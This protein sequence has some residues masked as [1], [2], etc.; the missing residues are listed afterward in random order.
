MRPIVCGLAALLYSWTAAWP[1][2]L[3]ND[4]RAAIAHNDFV[5][6]E[7]LTR[8][9]LAKGTTPEGILALSWLGRG[10]LAANQL[11]KADAYAGETRDLSMKLLRTRKLDD[12][13]SLPTAFGAYM[14]VHAQVLAARGQVADAVEFLQQQL[15]IYGGTSLHE[16]IQKNINLLSLEGKPAPALEEAEWLGAKPPAL[17]TLRGHP[18]LLFFWAHWCP[19]CKAEAPVIAGLQKS[20]GPKGL[21]VISPTKLYGY[22]NRG[23]EAQADVEKPYIEQV[24]AHYYSTMGDMFVPVSSR[25]FQVYGVST[26]PTLVLVDRN[27]IVRTYHPGNMTNDELSAQVQTLLSK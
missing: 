1:A 11:D 9:S 24:R 23:D 7:R 2:G 13:Q 27:G 4:V 15:E 22:V 6:A 18:V 12:E 20:F 3:V 5:A 8:E 26:T 21:V 25:N 10:A 16:R 19:D 17:D 14:E